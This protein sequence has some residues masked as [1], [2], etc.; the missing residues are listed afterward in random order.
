MRPVFRVLTLAWLAA[1]AALAFAD[2]LPRP[3]ASER[4]VRVESYDVEGGTAGE[5]RRD[6]DR[7]GPLFDGRRYDAR[8][9][10]YVRWHF[11]LLPTGG[12][13]RVARPRVDLEVTLTLPRWRR[14]LSAP[15]S[16]VER[17]QRYLAALRGHEDGHVAVGDEAAR[18]IER[19]LSGRPVQEDCGSAESEANAAAQAE[20]A[21]ARQ[22]DL[23]YDRET[24][25][26]ATQGARFP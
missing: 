4:P 20:I 22:E 6:L 2:G 8:T 9:R 23:R 16:L 1:A 25:Y 19:L 12:G 5:L 26:G 11:D 18:A 15:A 24:G 7:K 3:R 17:W 21:R 13:C 14:P 10:W